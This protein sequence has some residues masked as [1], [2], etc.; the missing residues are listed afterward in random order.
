MFLGVGERGKLQ[1]KLKY[2]G[3]KV[4]MVLVGSYK[5]ACVYQCSEHYCCHLVPAVQ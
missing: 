2:D 1:V 3:K 5:E 4:P